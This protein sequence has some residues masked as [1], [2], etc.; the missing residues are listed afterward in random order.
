MS[1]FL[2]RDG[3]YEIC[4]SIVDTNEKIDK[5]L[6]SYIL[7]RAHRCI[8]LYAQP[9]CIYD[10][11]KSK[12]LC[13]KLKIERAH[14]AVTSFDLSK[15]SIRSQPLSSHI[16]SITTYGCNH[17]INGNI[18]TVTSTLEPAQTYRL[19]ISTDIKCRYTRFDG[20]KDGGRFYTYDDL[21]KD[22]IIKGPETQTD[23][24]NTELY[25]RR[26]PSDPD[27]FQISEKGAKDP[28]RCEIQIWARCRNNIFPKNYKC[29][30]Y[31]RLKQKYHEKKVHNNKIVKNKNRWKWL[32]GRRKIWE[33]DKNRA[34]D[35]TN[36][37]NLIQKK[38]MDSKLSIY[39]RYRKRTKSKYR[40]DW[41]Y[42]KLSRS[43]DNGKWYVK[44]LGKDISFEENQNVTLGYV[45]SKQN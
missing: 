12:R 42:S 21:P 29:N 9:Q 37:L 2:G 43:M 23:L 1:E 8:P 18:L 39:I 26:M 3:T 36:I 32:K 28:V 27:N 6:S 7:T 25:I 40:G 38:F 45:N 11:G 33:D 16:K 13:I 19:I 35:G 15:Y 17:E 5:H 4:K 24:D 30:F 41:F 20:N 10:F 31:P 34:C 44:N 22:L 14:G